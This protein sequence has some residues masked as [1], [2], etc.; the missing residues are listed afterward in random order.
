MLL[1]SRHLFRSALFLIASAVVAP[2]ALRAAEIPIVLPSAAPA[3]VR[4][5]AQNLAGIL[6]HL[7]PQDRFPLAVTLPS[8]G[9]AILVGQSSDALV[10]PWLGGAA[11]TASESFVVRVEKTNGREL[12]LI[13]GADARGAAYGVYQLLSR[14]GCGFY[15]SG[16]ALPP[17]KPGAFD[18]AEWKLA[19][20]PLVRERLV[21]DWHNFLSGCSTWNR[22]EWRQWTEQSQKMGFNAIMVHAYGNNPMAGFTFQGQERPVGYLSTTVKGRD[23]STMHVTD[24]R[25]LHGGQVFDAPV[26]GADAGQVADGERVSAAQELMHGVFAD[27]AERGMGVYFAVDVDTPSANPQEL[28]TLLPESARFQVNG[29]TS[30]VTGSKPDRIWV[31]RP[32]TPEGYAYY[33][34]QVESHL[35]HYPQ[36]TRL[37]V[38]FRRDKTPWMNLKAGELPAEWQAEYAAE[39]A[40]TPGAEKFPQSAGLFAVSKIVRAFERALRERGASGVTLAAGTWGFEFLAGADRF[41]PAGVPLIGLDYDVLKEKPQLGTAESRASLR[42]IAARRPVIPVVWAHHDDGHYIGRPYTPLPDFASKLEDAKAAGF[43]IIHWTTRP[44]DIYFESL[45]RQVW[46]TTKD[47]PLTETCRTMAAAWFG[48]EHADRG[49]AYLN[50]WMT[51]APRFGRDTSDVFIDRK[52]E[53]SDAVVAG[54]RQRLAQLAEIGREAGVAPPGGGALLPAQ[55][56][57]LEYFRG[58]EEF[59]AAFFAAHVRFEESRQLLARGDLA[60]ARRALAECHAQEVIERYARFSSLGGITRG[61]QGLV[62]SLHTRWLSHIVRQ[63]QALGIEP[64]RIRLAPTSHDLLAQARG[65]FTFHFGVDHSLWECWGAAETGTE[66]FSLPPSLRLETGDVGPTYEEIAR[67]GITSA[68]PLTLVLRPI[69][70]KGAPANA[71][72][73]SL[74][75]GDYWLRLFLIEPDATAPGQRVFEVAVRTDTVSAS[76]KFQTLDTVDILQIAGGRNRLISRV[77]P[78]RIE[79]KA[80]GCAELRLTPLQGRML[81]CAVTVEPVTTP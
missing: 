57:R 44:L 5:A 47:Q 70:A 73:P 13:V 11:P 10:R 24:V 67:T 32:D 43:G 15:L 80:G 22:R 4:L 69:L 41:F 45:A 56:D 16:D 39:V 64:V 49:G 62:V 29:A 51:E 34:A 30:T 50:T 20:A 42:E 53:N 81:L 77:Y 48:A 36:I 60:G 12:G 35:R 38:W 21:F 37:V 33:R 58:L 76:A 1:P 78:I 68:Q 18:F 63:R 23:W 17:P 65:T 27:A 66:V 52:L 59:V 14:L 7:Y 46:R 26:F 55:R 28:V 19:N 71:K 6:Q 25:R 61:E 40:R 79:A 74:P 2:S 9:Q 31:P 72:I 3:N 75:A 54:C 8:A